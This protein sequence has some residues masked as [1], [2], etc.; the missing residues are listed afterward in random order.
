MSSSKGSITHKRVFVPAPSTTRGVPTKLGAT[1]DGTSI[2]Y[3]SGRTAII[4]PLDAASGAP[5]LLF[6]HAQ[7]VTVVKPVSAYYAASG[8]ASGTV[9]V[10]DT[11]G[12]YTVKFEAKP[13]ARI[14]DLAVDG[15]GKRFV[16]VG[17]GRSG[18]GA[19]FNLDTG[20]S[21][22]EISGH[23]KAVNAVAIRPGRPFKAVT[24]S[25]DFSVCFL[26]GVPFKYASTSRRHS[27]FVQSLDYAPDGS[28]FVS[29]GSDGQVFLYDGLTGE[30][31]SA[32]C[33]GEAAHAKGVFAASFAKDG[34]TVATSSADRSV[35]LW[36]V[37][38]GKVVQ[39]W[40]F[41]GDDL[42]QQQVGNVWAG[43]SLVSLSFSGDLSILDPRSSTPSRTLHGHQNPISALAVTPSH[44]TFLTG[45]SSG[46]VLA[47]SAAHGVVSPVKG[48]GHQGLVVDIVPSTEGEFVSAAYDDTM[49]QLGPSEFKAASLPTGAQPQ[50]LSSSS[51]AGLVFLATTSE[52]QVLHNGS[53]ASAVPLASPALSL[54]SNPSGT[55][56]AVGTDD[57]KVLVF[58]ISSPSSSPPQLRQTIELRAPATA[59]AYAPNENDHGGTQQHLVA[60]GLATGKV[61]LYDAHTGEVVHTRWAGAGRAQ[62]LVWNEAGTHLA[63]ASLDESVSVYSVDK[64]SVVVSIKNV[65]R[66]GVNSIV[67]AGPDQ[68]V[69]AGADGA[70]RVLDVAL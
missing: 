19:S 59:L 43:A 14:A 16:V 31:K 49:K 28:L 22:G 64:P 67:W 52:L 50:A 56:V 20:G 48:N 32:L 38:A 2:T 6:S 47:T 58:S 27:R 9:K 57:S 46:R 44:D 36:D 1:P 70:I 24:G 10:W 21:V 63:V 55:A 54:S 35:K 65:H 40:T 30:D 18:F 45:D 15:E 26:P 37:E 53:K 69:S 29:A 5:T 3:G 11:T 42:L 62:C 51:R 7:P 66:G 23:S 41:E 8:D 25:D 13:L 60:V 34:K 39:K 4:R 17:E 33:D 68:L 12:N 61:P